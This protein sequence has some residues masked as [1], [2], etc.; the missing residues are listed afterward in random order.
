M[1]LKPARFGGISGFKSGLTLLFIV[2]VMALFAV[3]LSSA[4]EDQSP[5]QFIEQG[6]T[7]PLPDFLNLLPAP[8]PGLGREASHLVFYSNRSAPQSLSSRAY[9]LY[10]VDLDGSHLTQL[11]QGSAYDLEPAWSPDGKSIALTVER[12]GNYEIFVMD[13]DGAHPRQLTHFASNCLSLA[14]SPDSKALAFVSDLSGDREIYLLS[15]RGDRRAPVNLTRFPDAEDSL[16]AWSPDGRQIAFVSDRGG[17]EDIY[18]MASDGSSVKRLTAS[19]GMNTAPSWSPDGSRIAFVSDREG[20]S[21]IYVMKAD[22]TGIRR[23][24]DHIAY[25][26]SPAWSPDGKRIAFTSTRENPRE[27]YNV[28]IMDADGSDLFQVTS[29]PFSDILPRWWP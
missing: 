19:P 21:E 7:A 2:A 20:N 5:S 3:G 17:K 26:W 11:T 29:G 9:E 23:L 24:T 14:W 16:P 12:E 13:A 22:G 4:L 25:D 18:L 1:T 27:R 6:S 10:R 8:P 15:L 28:F